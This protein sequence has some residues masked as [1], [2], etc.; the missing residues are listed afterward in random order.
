VR[1]AG[2]TAPSKGAHAYGDSPPQSEIY[3]L[4]KRLFASVNRFTSGATEFVQALFNQTRH[5]K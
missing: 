3:S 1:E 5:A 2:F 4:G